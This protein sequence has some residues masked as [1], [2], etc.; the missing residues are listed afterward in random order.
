MQDDRGTTQNQRTT[1]L[2]HTVSLGVR[3]PKCSGFHDVLRHVFAFPCESYY[4]HGKKCGEK[5][6]TN[7]VFCQRSDGFKLGLHYIKAL[8]SLTVSYWVKHSFMAHNSFSGP[9]NKLSENHFFFSPNNNKTINTLE[10]FVEL[11]HTT[12][13]RSRPPFTWNNQINYDPT[14]L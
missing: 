1:P 5:N 4:F 8:L 12:L 11:I 3:P 2:F 14:I 13:E 10:V 9:S 7:S 6:S